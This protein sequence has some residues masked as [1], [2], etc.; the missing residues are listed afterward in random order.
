MGHIFNKTEW[1][2]LL[3][4]LE[5]YIFLKIFSCAKKMGEEKNLREQK[6]PGFSSLMLQD[7]DDLKSLLQ[8]SRC[9]DHLWSRCCKHDCSY[10]SFFN[11]VSQPTKT[12]NY[13]QTRVFW[14]PPLSLFLFFISTQTK[15]KLQL[16]SVS[17]S[18]FFFLLFFFKT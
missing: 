6:S 2:H 16:L 1:K 18:L 5:A 11:D 4:V 12:R 3:K 7:V 8:C 14:L 10:W 9:C 17:F 13:A 15:S